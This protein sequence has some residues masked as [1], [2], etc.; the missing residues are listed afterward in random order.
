MTTKDTSY[1]CLYFIVRNDLKSMNAGKAEAHANHVGSQFVVT[2]QDENV[3]GYVQRMYHT[4]VNGERGFG[5]AIALEGD[6][7]VI[8]SVN[9]FLSTL[10]EEGAEDTNGVCA[11][12]YDSVIDPTYPYT[13]LVTGQPSTREELTAFWWFA[14]SDDPRYEPLRKKL[15]LKP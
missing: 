13:D 6:K 7:E 15:K 3:R 1:P 8:D 5:T 12:S 14:M 4:W 11:Y 9:S 10:C 2:M